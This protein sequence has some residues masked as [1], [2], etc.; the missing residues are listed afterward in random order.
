MIQQPV[1]PRVPLALQ[2][3][4]GVTIDPVTGIVTLNTTALSS[5]LAGQLLAAAV[6]GLPTVDPHVV[7]QCWNDGNVIAISAG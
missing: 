5:T 7:G 6:P 1:I 2:A 3:T 4:G